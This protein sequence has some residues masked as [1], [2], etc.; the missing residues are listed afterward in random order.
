MVADFQNNPD[1][2]FV[3]DFPV[4]AAGFVAI[5]GNAMEQLADV[6]M[7]W[8][9][10]QPLPPLAQDIV[11]VQSNGVA[12]WFKMRTAA[13][14][15]VCAGTAVQLAA[16]FAWQ[17][18]RQILGPHAVPAISPLDEAPMTWRLVR[19]IPALLSN[20]QSATVFAPLRRFLTAR[21]ASAADF[22]P[23]HPQTPSTP[24]AI[25]GRGCAATQPI[26]ADDDSIDTQRLC[27]LAARI[28]DVFDQ[29]QVYRADWLAAWEAGA[30]D[31]PAFATQAAQPLPADLAWQPALWRA[32]LADLSAD[33]RT[34]TRAAVRA[35]VIARLNTAAPGSIAALPARVSVLGISHMP[36]SMLEFLVALSRHTQVLLAVPNP[37]RY[38]WADAIDGR[39]L[40]RRARR[41]QPLRAGRDLA[42]IDLSDMHAHAHPLLMAWARQSRD[43]V[44]LLD[45]WDVDSAATASHWSLPRIDVFDD[46]PTWSG[47]L[48]QQVQRSIRDLVPLAEHPRAALGPAIA[49]DDQSIVFHRAHGL[50]RE[51][52]VLHDALLTALASRDDHPRALTPKDIIVM[53]PDVRAAAPHIRAVFGQYP[54]HD[55]RHIPFDIADLSVQNTS[56]I[57]GAL[58]QLL[59]MGEQRWTLPVLCDWLEI[60]AVAARFGL[61][62]ADTAQ[63]Q[64]WMHDAGLRWG[65]NAEHR[66]ELGLP[67][68]GEQNTAAFAL[69][70]MLR[71]WIW[72]DVERVDEDGPAPYAAIAGMSA[73]AVGALWALVRTLD[74]W[75]ERA[76]TEATPEHWAAAL[77]A[78]ADALF[79]PTD[80]AEHIAIANWH[81]AIDGWLRQCEAARFD[82]PI[83][84]AAV[85]APLE[86]T[87]S[88]PAPQQRFHAGGVTFCTHMPMRAIPFEMVCLLGLDEGQ[89]PRRAT[90]NGL[91]LM[92]RAGHY[93]P[94]DR[95]RRDHDRQLMLEAL[96]S[97]R[98][99][100]YLSHSAHSV[101]DHTSAPPSV[102]LAQLRDYLAAGWAAKNQYSPD[103]P[104]N[105]ENP[106]N[107]RIAAHADASPLLA[108]RTFDH[109]M[110]PFSRRYFEE[111]TQNHTWAREW[112]HV[113]IA[114]NPENLQNASENAQTPSNKNANLGRGCL[115][116]PEP[117]PTTITVAQ[118]I[119]FFKNPAA[120]YFKNCLHIQFGDDE[121]PPP[122]DEPVSLNHLE[123]YKIQ[124]AIQEKITQDFENHLQHK[125]NSAPFHINAA[126]TQA[127]AAH[128]AAGT[129]PIAAAGRAIAQQLHT[130][131]G[132][133]LEHWAEL[134]ST[135]AAKF[136]AAPLTLAHP[137]WPLHDWPQNL[138][139]K[140]LDEIDDFNN[141][142]IALELHPRKLLSGD[143]DPCPR[144]NSA[145]FAAFV[146]QMLAQ[147]CDIPA[148][149]WLL[150]T[151]GWVRL[152][153]NLENTEDNPIIQPEDYLKTL[154]FIFAQGQKS[155]LPL[156]QKTAIAFAHTPEN[157]N[158]ENAA[159][160]A[161][162]GNYQSQGECQENPYW[163]RMYPDFESLIAEQSNGQNSNPDNNDIFKSSLFY[164]YANAVY[165]PF[166][167]YLKHHSICGSWTP[168][169]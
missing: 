45:D 163:Q 65:L 75:A 153:I 73:Y 142:A 30:D 57:L 154:Q 26:A 33:E 82:A 116:T 59:H 158:P 52:E 31:L 58:T 107:I 67:S 156:P 105:P 70:R 77:R 22:A 122:E 103:N 145:L 164:E 62:E 118:L 117:A 119:A 144:A 60:P 98:R 53:L 136:A 112:L 37:C 167:H 137:L 10:A 35:A 4:P 34:A 43:F 121:N 15:G 83:A 157:K 11:L 159:R 17:S 104:D 138:H 99:T 41:R 140:S 129:L 44:R 71:G 6:L 120:N 78:L 166:L 95:Q 32:L 90:P 101:R 51:L 135:H 133:G 12:E 162:C 124:S 161:Y 13:R 84:L 87:L 79:T 72:G 9:A 111:N 50:V 76:R 92:Q 160:G 47:T 97:A 5:H 113:H 168:S 64:S 109:P 20:P 1:N 23:Q 25:L 106:L 88:A 81:D 48:L 54:A 110:Q 169:T 80:E 3:T 61:D 151:D 66:A 19:L 128:Q 36:Q 14:Q 63:L 49:A 139:T 38:H 134:R 40:L 148:Q 150:G 152:G 147:A 18:W 96:L 141:P 42:N 27:E 155:P 146:R 127:I 56:A 16:R 102:L 46:A 21:N 94:G 114:D 149:T 130:A 2:D 125:N 85:A 29:Y 39:E 165:A 7:D 115:P 8:Q 69:E 131:L 132:A 86:Q 143:K 126:L 89:W 93:R 123:L 74:A 100:L 91:D 68:V 55:P 28:A 24:K 108:Q